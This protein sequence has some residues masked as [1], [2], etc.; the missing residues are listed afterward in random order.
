MAQCSNC[1]RD[2]IPGTLTCECGNRF[3]AKLELP[4]IKLNSHGGPSLDFNL[5]TYGINQVP[6]FEK[7]DLEKMAVNLGGGTAER[8][9]SY[10]PTF[11]LGKEGQPGAGMQKPFG[12]VRL[13]DNS[14]YIIDFNADS[15]RVRVQRFDS[16]TGAF[17]NVIREFELGQGQNAFDTPAGIAADENSNFYIADMG[18][19][20]IHAYDSSGNLLSILGSE[21]TGDQQLLNPQD[22]D[23]GTNRDLYIAD[24]GNNRIVVW[25]KMGNPIRVIGINRLEEGEN[26]LQAGSAAG[27]FDE[28]HGVTVD[29][30]GNIF[31]ADTNNHRV[32]KFNSSGEHVLTFGEEGDRAGQFLFPN[33]LRVSA[34]GSVF[35]SDL[36]SRRI[37]KFGEDGNFIFEILLPEDSGSVGDFEVDPEGKILVALRRSNMILKLEVI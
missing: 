5:P 26:W 13:V 9:R 7:V 32:Q 1:G 21:G 28:P 35:V 6:G 10:R 37:Q 14:M 19:S 22:V 3:D 20:S 4:G 12:I 27:E 36:N 16:V 18:T 33:D 11:L 25:D 2:I 30:R 24:T 34:D 29:D 23:L 17:M 15:T 8:G 31:V